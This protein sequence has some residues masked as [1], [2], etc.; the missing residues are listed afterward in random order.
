MVIAA[1][2]KRSTWSGCQ[3]RGKINLHRDLKKCAGCVII[4]LSKIGKNVLI[5]NAPL[6]VL[7]P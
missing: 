7:G 2:R 5:I 3:F 4:K 6:R 1:S